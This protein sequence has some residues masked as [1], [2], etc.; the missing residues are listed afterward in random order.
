MTREAITLLKCTSSAND[1]LREPGR[2]GLY[3]TPYS[4][5]VPL[6]VI[7]LLENSVKII[8]RKLR[9]LHGA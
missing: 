3:E 4:A 1:D 6:N 8:L 7:N 2:N 5:Y 9:W